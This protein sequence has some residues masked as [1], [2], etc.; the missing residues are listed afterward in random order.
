MDYIFKSG[1]ITLIIG[2][3]YRK[4]LENFVQLKDGHA[5]YY[6]KNYHCKTYFIRRN[7]PN[8]KNRNIF[9]LCIDVLLQIPNKKKFS[10]INFCEYG[11]FIFR[12]TLDF[13]GFEEILQN[14]T[15]TAY[16]TF[17]IDKI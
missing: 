16:A 9:K 8:S 3:K 2:T 7:F 12:K 1:S 5:Y 6:K 14:Y 13:I 17:S 11:S 4:E 10:Q 15:L